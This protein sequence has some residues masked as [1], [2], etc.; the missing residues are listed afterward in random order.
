MVEA[1]ARCKKYRYADWLIIGFGLFL[2][3][4]TVLA[5]IVLLSLWQ[6]GNG[7]AVVEA[8]HQI[9]SIAVTDETDHHLQKKDKSHSQTP[10]GAKS[11]AK[12]A[13]YFD[14]ES[15]AEHAK[16]IR[17]WHRAS[18]ISNPRRRLLGVPEAVRLSGLTQWDL[19]QL[20][21]FFDVASKVILAVPPLWTGKN[22]ERQLETC[23]NLLN[24]SRGA[25]FLFFAATASNATTNAA[26]IFA[27]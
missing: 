21:W 8:E 12:G 27:R 4:V 9:K 26:Q 22:V 18:S 1:G 20:Q 24:V 25:A 19:Q 2:A 5:P 13:T 6:K 3:T 15:L 23:H 7:K 14:D 11:I 17:I 10:S 16:S